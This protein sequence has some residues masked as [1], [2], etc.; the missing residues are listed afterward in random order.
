MVISAADR[1]AGRG[2]AA[3]AVTHPA[4]GNLSRSE[5][6]RRRF[7][8]CR[9]IR[10]GMR[11]CDVVRKY[12]V[13][14]TSV[15]KWAHWLRSGRDLNRQ[16]ATGRP[17]RVRRD[18]IWEILDAHPMPSRMLRAEIEE[19]YGVRYSQRQ[20]ER[21]IDRYRL[22]KEHFRSSTRPENSKL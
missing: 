7:D 19:R 14:R 6:E 1:E 20:C 11:Q 5:M 22:R 4:R 18:L 21:L 15:S 13:S 16:K 10:A 3:A 8:A 17:P 9:D 2:T 12:G